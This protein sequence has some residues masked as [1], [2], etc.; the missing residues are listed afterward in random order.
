MDF[1][2]IREFPLRG[3]ETAW[4]GFL[5]QAELP[6]HYTAPEFFLEKHLARLHPFAILAFG[7]SGI[8]GVLTGLH[9]SDRT[10]SGLAVRPQVCLHQGAD[11]NAVTE[12][13][14]DGL[15]AE[16]ASSDLVEVYS[17]TPL[18]A[19]GFQ[20]H[21]MEGPVVLDLKQ[22]LEALFGQLDRKRRNNIRFAEKN[23][24]E[25]S[26]VQTLEEFR[27]YYQDVYCAW[28]STPRKQIRG[29][30]TTLEG[31]ERRFELN[32]CRK[33]FAAWFQGKMVAGMFLRFHP[34]GLVEYAAG[35]SIDEA[36]HLKP[37]DLVQW[38]AIEWACRQG[39]RTYSLGGSGPFHREFGGAVAAVYRYRLDQSRLHLYSLR[40]AIAGFARKI[41]HVMPK[42]IQRVAQRVR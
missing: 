22:P 17:W 16:A 37:N 14:I 21:Q 18:P 5:A 39:F 12:A 32:P 6:T 34:G 4:R 33:L 30:E 29:A 8:T 19:R 35:H 15:R 24:V 1:A 40:D 28:R 38:R 31:F 11:R 10:V 2:V 9:E 20:V 42:P 36:L 25:T 7:R 27:A 3:L 13:F 41:L 23:G 26:E